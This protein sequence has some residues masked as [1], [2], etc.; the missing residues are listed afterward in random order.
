MQFTITKSGLE[1][2]DTCRAW[3]LANLLYAGCQGSL[4]PL[5]S[6]T[7][8]WFV[9][10]VQSDLGR[11]D[12][13]GSDQW[14]A[15]KADENWQNVFLTYKRQW[16]GRRDDAIAVLER[17]ARMILDR[18]STTGLVA[19]FDG[20][21]TLPGPLDP[22]AFKGL[23]GRTLGDYGEGQTSVDEIN[24]ALGCLGAVT[25]Q[26][27]KLQRVTGGKWEHY[28]TL[29]VPELVLLDNF[30]E[31]RELVG[32]RPNLNYAG[33]RVAAAHYAVVLA[34][35]VREKGA[36]RP[37]LP[38]RFS[39]LLYFSLFRSGQQVKPAGGGA[40]SVGP[41]IELALKNASAATNV[42]ETWDY[43]FRRGSVKGCDDL[44]HA[45]TELVLDPSRDTYYRHARI[46]SR[47]IFDSNRRVKR[48]KLYSE[49][50]L[51]EVMNYVE[52]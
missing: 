24:W 8:A 3:G 26:N 34:D 2:F 6:D 48:D 29:P 42:F 15:L 11:L 31:V 30:R 4:S 13:A 22:S 51:T 5:I 35:A 50:S 41:L 17:S 36:G 18:A 27:Y 38:M 44:A 49:D 14:R 20:D 45:V 43:L 16:T 12:L 25:A 7:G 21:T 1:I 47:Y 9:L 37:D 28:V 10:T 46:F 23:R 39:K 33:V 19:D 32:K 40:V 52:R